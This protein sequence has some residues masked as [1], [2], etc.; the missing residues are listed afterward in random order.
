MVAVAA[1]VL[2]RR[3]EAQVELA[4]PVVVEAEAAVQLP[5]RKEQAGAAAL[6]ACFFHFRID[7]GQRR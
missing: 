1:V 3:Q 6:A 5:E 7:Q 2:V 4:L